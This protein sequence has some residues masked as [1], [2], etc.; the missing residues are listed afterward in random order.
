[1]VKDLMKKKGYE[2]NP[3]K[4]LLDLWKMGLYPVGIL[5][6]KKF[7]IYYVPLKRTKK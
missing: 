2:K 4:E 1:V 3:F 7:H 6:D 5:K